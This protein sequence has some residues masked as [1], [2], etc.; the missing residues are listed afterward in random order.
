MVWIKTNLGPVIRQAINERP[1]SRYTED[2]LAGMV[3]R[4]VH[5]L[6]ERR[7][8]I[9]PAANLE[10]MAPLMR[11]DYGARRGRTV[12]QF[13]GYS[14]FQI[15][16]DSYPAFIEAG[17]WEDPLASAKKAID[18]LEEKRIYLF[19]RHGKTLSA[20]T[21][22]RAITAAYN[23]GQGNVH[24]AL[25]SGFPVDYYTH[26]RDYSKMVWVYRNFYRTL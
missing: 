24:K 19:P 8:K 10:T 21:F 16:I 4:E 12:K 2:W 23:C 1:G 26:G 18:V 5:N 14:F 15:D 17:L 7:L 11:G 6:I 22:D 25:R 9:D 20:D 13:H 3:Y